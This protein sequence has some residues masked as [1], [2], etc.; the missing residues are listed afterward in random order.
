MQWKSILKVVPL[1]RE[2]LYVWNQGG[3]V[4]MSTFVPYCERVPLEAKIPLRLTTLGSQ[5][6]CFTFSAPAK[7]VFCELFKQPHP[8]HFRQLQVSRWQHQGR[9]VPGATQRTKSFLLRAPST[10]SERAGLEFH[11]SS[12]AKAPSNAKQDSKT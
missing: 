2:F 1:L 11:L 7:L 5:D 6:S 10:A 9:E 3:P 8:L 4:L 12:L